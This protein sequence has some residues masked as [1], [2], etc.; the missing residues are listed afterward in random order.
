MFRRGNIKGF[1][2]VLAICLVIFTPLLIEAH[3]DILDV[4]APMQPT[5]E[6]FLGP[7]AQL[8]D[9]LSGVSDSKPENRP[10]R[11]TVRPTA[12]VGIQGLRPKIANR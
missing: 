2:L 10:R 5:N 7:F 11:S 9:Q 1:I 3:N 4:A 12:S 8:S 6:A